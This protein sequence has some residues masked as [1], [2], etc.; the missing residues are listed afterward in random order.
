MLR[1]EF[2]G[3]AERERTA[4][5]GTSAQLLGLPASDAPLGVP[6]SA[7]GGLGPDPQRRGLESRSAV[8]HRTLIAVALF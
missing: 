8:A 4:P 6:F 2:T 5:F 3:R 7:P 1:A